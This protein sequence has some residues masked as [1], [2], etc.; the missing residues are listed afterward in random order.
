VDCYQNVSLYNFHYAVP[1]SVWENYELNKPICYDESGGSGPADLPYRTSGW[2]FILAGGSVFDNLDYSFYVGYEDGSGIPPQKTP[3]G[4][5]GPTIR[6]QINILQNFIMSL[7][8]LNMESNITL[9]KSIEPSNIQYGVFAHNQGTTY[10]LYFV[11]NTQNHQS[12]FNLNYLI[13]K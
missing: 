13:R 8:F 3:T 1:L 5:G 4:G 10:A 12:S 9:I 6:A 7:D 11:N 2:L